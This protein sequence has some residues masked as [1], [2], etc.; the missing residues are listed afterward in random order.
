[1]TVLSNKL[2]YKLHLALKSLYYFRHSLYYF[3]TETSCLYWLVVSVELKLLP[4]FMI[5]VGLP[6]AHLETVLFAVCL[7]RIGNINMAFVLVQIFLCAT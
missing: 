2:Q 5:G 3:R 1:M 4:P 7:V 6:F